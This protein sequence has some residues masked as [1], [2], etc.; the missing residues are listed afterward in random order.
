MITDTKETTYLIGEKYM[1]PENYVTGADPGDLYSAMSGD[2]IGLIRWG[3]TTLLPSMDRTANNNPPAPA[4]ATRIFGS[5]HPAGW[6]AAFCDEHVQLIGW[7]ID[8][9]LHQTMAT[10]NGVRSLGYAVVD[11]SKIPH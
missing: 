11:P 7:A 2:D 9:N 5:S 10:R 1:S 3:N 4:T 8:G 6:H